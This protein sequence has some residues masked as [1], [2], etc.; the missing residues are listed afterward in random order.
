[1]KVKVMEVDVARKRIGLSM[2]LDA[3]PARPS[4]ERNER[5]DRGGRDNRGTLNAYRPKQE[6]VRNSSM[7]DKLAAL[8]R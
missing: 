6:E 4:G 3:A 8:R 1:V 2:K 5:S 7:A